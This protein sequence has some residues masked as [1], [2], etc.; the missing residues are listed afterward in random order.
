[1]EVADP[2]GLF[3]F[4]IEDGLRG[5]IQLAL[6]LVDIDRQSS[7]G[8]RCVEPG[9][10]PLGTPPWCRWTGRYYEDSS[11]TEIQ[12]S[13]IRKRKSHF[14]LIFIPAVPVLAEIKNSLRVVIQKVA[15]AAIKFNSKSHQQT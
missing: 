13:S 6:V 11:P 8:R 15:L 2:L 3:I 10:W 1:M 5:L 14:D 9:V 4:G 7:S 12:Q